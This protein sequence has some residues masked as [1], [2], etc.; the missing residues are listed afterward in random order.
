LRSV[1]GGSTV[2]QPGLNMI[3]VF[4]DTNAFNTPREK[5][6]SLPRFFLINLIPI[7]ER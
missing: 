3:F 7:E 4:N 5:L 1:R 2:L 6:A